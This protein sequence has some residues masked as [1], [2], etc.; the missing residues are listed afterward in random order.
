M[1]QPT[2]P[3]LRKTIDDRLA[4]LAEQQQQLAARAQ[5]LLAVK[6]TSERKRETRRRQIVGAAIIAAAEDLEFRQAVSRLLDT[7]ITKKAE[8][9]AVADLLPSPAPE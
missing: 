9:A 8:R 1:D 4:S 2:P 7:W 6:E 3:R 5:S